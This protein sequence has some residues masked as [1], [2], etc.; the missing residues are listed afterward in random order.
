MTGG[1]HWLD[2]VVI[3]LYLIGM[4]AIGAWFSRKNTTTEEYFVGGRSYAGWVIGLSLVGT[5]ISSVSFLAYP[6]DAFKT[7]WIRFVPNLMLPLGVLLASKLFLPYYR[8]RNITSAYE[9][10]E[11]RFGPSVRLYAALMNILGQLLRNSIILF[12]V[13]FIMEELTGMAPWLCILLSGLCI[14][15][16]TVIGG[17]NAVI[18]TDVVQVVVLLGG[19]L[20]C[21]LTVLHH[22]PGGLEQVLE[23]GMADGKFSFCDFVN[24]IP[25]PVSWELT[26]Q[27]KTISMMLLLGL[28]GFLGAYSSDQTTIQRYCASKDTREAKKAMWFCVGSSLPIWAFFMF[29]GTALYVFFK[30]F[31][32]PESMQMLDGV[33]PAEGILPY[34]VV[35]YLPPG[36]TG[37]VLA[38]ILAASMS[39]LDSG[40]NAVATI[41]VVDIYRRHMV[42]NRPDR[43]YLHV[44]W[45]ISVVAAAVMI[46]GAIVLVTVKMRTLMDMAN[47]LMSFLGGGMLGLYL[48]GFLTKRGNHK[49]VWCGVVLTWCFS[50]WTVLAS[51]GLL[52][53][54]MTV[55]FDLYYTSL[56][57]NIIMFVVGYLAGTCFPWGRRTKALP[58]QPTANLFHDK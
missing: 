17:I 21:L 55:P 47:I 39:S 56:I 8:S 5:S 16:Y 48:L 54:S 53:E 44:A 24:G 41:G 2:G 19:A 46:G 25:E 20:F 29:L 34:F 26:L 3:A 1:F 38:A 58:A 4:L 18:W 15:V 13:S 49:A 36:G 37:L 51:R 32:T 7:A 10:L 50:F 31:P 9:Y 6:G 27:H 23:V 40:I 57:G 43:H 12:L 33:R 42:K 35:R 28:L 14:A 22:L 11:D 45:G 30:I 52:P